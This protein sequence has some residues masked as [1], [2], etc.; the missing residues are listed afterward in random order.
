MIII[1]H[2]ASSGE[3]SGIARRTGDFLRRTVFLLTL[4]PV[5]HIKPAYWIH[6]F[7]L[8]HALT[9]V[10]CHYAGLQD[11]LFLT[12]LTMALIAILCLKKG[13]SPEFTAINLVLANIFGFI[14]GQLGAQL[15]S[16]LVPGRDILQHAVATAATTE[17]LGWSLEYLAPRALPGSSRSR[18]YHPVWVA[19]AVLLVFLLRV[20]VSHIFTEGALKGLNA[21]A[22]LREFMGNSS[23][24]LVL[25]LALFVFLYMLSLILSMRDEMRR[26]R[27]DRHRAE[28]R[29]MTL[30]HQVNPHFLFNS[31][32]I[33]DSIVQN[34]TREEAGEFIHR[35]AH[36]YR[37]LLQR[38]DDEQVPVG[39]ELDFV[40]EYAALLRI[41]FPEGLVIENCVREEDRGHMTVPCTLQLLIENA[42]K[43]NTISADNPLCIRLDSDGRFITV[44]NNLIPKLSTP[45]STGL[46]LKYIRQQFIDLSGQEV[47]VEKTASHFR[48]RLP[49]L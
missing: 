42:T 28:F 1:Y 27:E 24:I 8:L 18:K 15:L 22:L 12:V 32:N 33:L 25:E 46:G 49:L 44:E 2:Y 21:M 43:H 9:T 41:R 23:A 20:I 6:G 39:D 34:G 5:K 29:Y 38:G 11:G 47:R 26:Q 35:L 7:A 13:L 37:Y 3:I 31:L 19:A 48:V 30:K 14:V 40:E 4:A 10:L 16:L 45:A 36:I 17:L